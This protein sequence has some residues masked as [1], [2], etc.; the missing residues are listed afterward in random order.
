MDITNVLT[1]IISA[2]SAVAFGYCFPKIHS[3]IKRWRF[4]KDINRNKKHVTLCARHPDKEFCNAA[5]EVSTIIL[6]IAIIMSRSASV[7]APAVFVATVAFMAEIALIKVGFLYPPSS[8][9]IVRAPLTVIGVI[10]IFAISASGEYLTEYVRKKDSN[11]RT[12]N[13]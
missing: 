5:S 7:F 9:S 13:D 1:S 4:R 10:W 3:K 2:I 11:G 8:L 6:K 12:K